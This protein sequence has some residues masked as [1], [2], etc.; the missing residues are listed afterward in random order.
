MSL[1]DE[2]E[3]LRKLHQDGALTSAEFEAAKGA[4][5]GVGT[6][7]AALPAQEKEPAKSGCFLIALAVVVLSC[8]GYFFLVAVF[9][10]PP[11]AISGVREKTLSVSIQHS[12]TEIRITNTGS[13]RAIGEEITIYINGMPPFTYKATAQFPA[14]NEYVDIPLASFV[15]K[16]GQRFNPAN[17]AVVETWIGGAGYDFQ[18]RR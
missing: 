18:Q 11:G 3:K 14:L 13:S 16:N 10:D 7:P 5:I 17:E 9:N 1:P 4:L 2:L 12:P 6:P 8:V 15:K